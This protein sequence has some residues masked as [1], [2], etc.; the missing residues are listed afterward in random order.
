MSGLFDAKSS[1]TRGMLWPSWQSGTVDPSQLASSIYKL[2]TPSFE[3]VS[4]KNEIPF[5][6]WNKIES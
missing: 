4:K 2:I 3:K 1:K 5:S 6:F